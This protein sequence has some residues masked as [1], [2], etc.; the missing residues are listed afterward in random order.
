MGQ[1][2]HLYQILFG[3]IGLCIGGAVYLFIV[4]MKDLP[5]LLY[6]SSALVFWATIVA[7]IYTMAWVWNQISD[8]EQ[9]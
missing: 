9:R 4:A 2:R 1:I 5:P 6:F 7:T 8:G 3:V